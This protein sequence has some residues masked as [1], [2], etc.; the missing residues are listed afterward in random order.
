[1]RAKKQKVFSQPENLSLID[2]RSDQDGL[3]IVLEDISQE[4][5]ARNTL[6]RYLEKD[7]VDQVLGDPD[8][9][10]LGGSAAR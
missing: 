3:V 2:Q 8:K 5:R 10:V 1:M 4:K 7:I 6:T 9:Q